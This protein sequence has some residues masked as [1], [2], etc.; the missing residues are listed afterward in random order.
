[1]PG[2][3]AGCSRRTGNSRS[4]RRA[5]VFDAVPVQRTARRTRGPERR[6]GRRANGRQKKPGRQAPEQQRQEENGDAA[7]QCR[8]RT[9]RKDSGIAAEF[10][11]FFEKLTGG[12]RLRSPPYFCGLRRN[13]GRPSGHR[14]TGSAPRPLPPARHLWVLATGAL[15]PPVACA[16]VTARVVPLRADRFR[17]DGSR[18]VRPRCCC[19]RSA[20]WRPCLVR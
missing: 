2:E 20:G 13:A 5:S 6:G 9:E 4:A 7:A 1:M 16:S 10:E 18:R 3:T 15:P 19:R 8:P 12:V 11:K 14:A 17:R